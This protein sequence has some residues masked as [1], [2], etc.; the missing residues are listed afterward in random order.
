MF[1]FDLE[2]LRPYNN[3]RKY[4]EGFSVRLKGQFRNMGMNK[5]NLVSS[6]F[7]HQTVGGKRLSLAVS[8]IISH[9]NISECSRVV[10][11]M[12]LMPSGYVFLIASLASIKAVRSVLAV[13]YF[14][15]SI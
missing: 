12:P 9:D 14:W 11:Y 5:I 7:L 13:G 1:R 8:A 10:S 2:K 3:G 4:P 15:L 6:P